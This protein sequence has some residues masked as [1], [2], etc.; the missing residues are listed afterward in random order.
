[1]QRA[2]VFKKKQGDEM[3]QLIIGFLMPVISLC[4]A[5]IKATDGA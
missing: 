4:A 5:E 1:M 2:P 3:D